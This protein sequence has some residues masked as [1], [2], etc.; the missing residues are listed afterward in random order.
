MWRKSGVYGFCHIPS[1][2]WY[3]GSSVSIGRRKADHLCSLRHNRNLSAK[4]QNAWN[5]YGEAEFEFR[6]LELVPDAAALLGREEAWV[7]TLDSI[8]AGFNILPVFT[9]IDVAARRGKQKIASIGRTHTPETKAKM[10]AAHKL[11]G[12]PTAET[13]RKISAA[14]T[15]RRLSSPQHVQRMRERPVS[16]RPTPAIIAAQQARVGVPRPE[17]VRKKIS[18]TLTGHPVSSET[19]RKMSENR[20]QEFCKNGHRLSETR[21]SRGQCHRCKMDRQRQ[22]R[23]ARP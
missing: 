20:R 5:R 21:N 8:N 14:L 23:A 10:S 13:G 3:V 11:R 18:G 12:G 17:E 9:Q 16:W 19:L 2:R 15:G 22:Y 6:V 7:N 4:L 1:Q